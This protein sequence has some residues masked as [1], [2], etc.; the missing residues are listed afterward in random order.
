MTST[1]DFASFLAQFQGVEP[2]GPGLSCAGVVSPCEADLGELE[3][4]D[5]W[6][7]N[8]AFVCEEDLGPF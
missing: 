5:E 6:T 2:L 3:F 4:C 8:P 1:V 7:F